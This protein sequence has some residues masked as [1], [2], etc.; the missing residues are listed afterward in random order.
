LSL[1]EFEQVGRIGFVTLNR[2][3]KKNAFNTPMALEL[4]EAIDRVEESDE[5][6]V[7]VLRAVTGGARPVFSAGYDLTGGI[8]DEHGAFTERGGF[9]GL[10]SR[11]RTKPLIAAVDGLAIA[12]GFEL[13]LACDL[14][15]AARTASFALAEVKW[16]LV[17]AAGG[18]FRLTRILGRPAAM[19]LVLTGSEL[20]AERAYQLGLVSRLAEDGDVDKVALDLATT[21]AANAPVAVRLNRAAVWESEQADDGEAWAMCERLTDAVNASEDSAEGV[22]AFLERRA[23]EWTGR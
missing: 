11:E 12:G 7:A 10:T 5:I 3:E 6:R 15:V 8:G 9:G 22:R 20:G 19:D 18:V 21:I 2:P 16:N 13:V 1:V 4:E 17:A 23:P 14:I